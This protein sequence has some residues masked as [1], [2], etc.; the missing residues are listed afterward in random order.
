[1]KLNDEITFYFSFNHILL[2][3]FG[4]Y[5]ILNMLCVKKWPKLK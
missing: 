2:T 3:I 4:N 1:M 5:M